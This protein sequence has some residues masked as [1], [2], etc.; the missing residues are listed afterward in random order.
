MSLPNLPAEPTETSDGTLLQDYVWARETCAIICRT[1]SRIKQ[2]VTQL[3]MMF[4]AIRCLNLWFKQRKSELEICEN[5][6]KQSNEETGRLTQA[7]VAQ[8]DDSLGVIQNQMEQGQNNAAVMYHTFHHKV[9]SIKRY[10]VDL[11]K[12]RQRVSD[13]LEHVIA[14][15]GKSD[16]GGWLTRQPGLSNERRW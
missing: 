3:Q 7:W 4:T 12:L 6:M 1:E 2:M 9:A 8:A 15:Y 16:I 11:E 10:M 5:F 14:V 13:K